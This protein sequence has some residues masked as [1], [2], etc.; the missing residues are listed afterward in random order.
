M[1]T[2]DDTIYA[3]SLPAVHDSVV[4][5]LKDAN[6]KTANTQAASTMTQTTLHR[7]WKPK[8][9]PKPV[10]LFKYFHKT[11]KNKTPKNKVAKNNL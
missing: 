8:P 6:R 2:P 5:T 3:V 4:I 10:T 9:K 11:A 7:F 1:L